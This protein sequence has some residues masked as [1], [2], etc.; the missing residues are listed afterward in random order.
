MASICF[1]F[2]WSIMG[3]IRMKGDFGPDDFFK[4]AAII[5]LVFTFLWSY[6]I[7]VLI[8][9]VV[10]CTCLGAACQQCLVSIVGALV[11]GQV[12]GHVTSRIPQ[13]QA[14][15]TTVNVELISA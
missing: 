4:V 14:A 5:T 1:F 12:G 10:F 9:L 8:I 15:T 11:P 7:I 2:V 6:F 13:Q 3:A